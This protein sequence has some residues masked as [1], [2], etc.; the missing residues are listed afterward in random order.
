MLFSVYS[1]W[2]RQVLGRDEVIVAAIYT[3]FSISDVEIESVEN[4]LIPPL[5]PLGI[6]DRS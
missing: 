2:L 1:I 4:C 6:I 5:R 3:Q